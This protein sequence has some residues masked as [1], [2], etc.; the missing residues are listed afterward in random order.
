MQEQNFDLEGYVKQRLSEIRNTDERGFAREALLKGFL[1]AMQVMEERYRSLEERVR[2][3]IEVPG[4]R[5]AVRTIVIRGQDYDAANHTW[6]PVCRDDVEDGMTYRRIYFRGSVKEKGNFEQQDFFTAVDSTGQARRVGVR[7]TEDYR[8]AVE[9]LYSLFVYNR[10][11]WNTVNTGDLDRFY[12]VYLME[13]A[14][15]LGKEETFQRDGVSRRDDT[16]AEKGLLRVESE[17]EEKENL[18]G[19]EID[20]GEWEKLIDRDCIALWNLEY[21]TF[22]SM[23]FMVPCMDGKYYEHELNL[24]EYE[25]DCGYMVKGNEDILSIRHE[26][27]RILMVSPKEAF[28]RWQACRFGRQPDTDSYGYHHRIL[29][30]ERKERFAD[31]LAV[32]Y[33]QGIHSRT[34]LF[35]IVE[36]LNADSKIRL[37]DCQIRDKERAYSYLADMNWFLREDLFPMETRKVLELTFERPAGSAGMNRDEGEDH[38]DPEGEDMIRY[39]ISQIQLLFDEYRCV[40]RLV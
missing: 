31:H 27:G 13:E 2:R 18:S 34:E 29:G 16:R 24:K 28:E 8:K 19:W 35:R 12:D 11:P 1:P 14:D 37:I 17:N 4:S 33:G 38:Y 26:S 39:V 7:R 15:D 3:E 10:V 22:R 21:F 25:P 30:N 23:K 6:F 40:G 20:F 36:E 9:E 5:Y 32:R